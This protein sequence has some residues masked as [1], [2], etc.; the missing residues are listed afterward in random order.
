MNRIFEEG[1]W[2]AEWK[3]LDRIDYSAGVLHATEAY[4]YVTKILLQDSPEMIV[5]L[6]C[7]E[8]AIWAYEKLSQRPEVSQKYLDQLTFN[9]NPGDRSLWP[10]MGNALRHS[11][12]WGIHV[13]FPGETWL[14]RACMDLM[15]VQILPDGLMYDGRRVQKLDVEFIYDPE[16]MNRFISE[17]SHLKIGVM[18]GYAQQ[19]VAPLQENFGIVVDRWNVIE[20]SKMYSE[21]KLKDFP[22]TVEAMINMDCELLLCAAGWLTSIYQKTALDCGIRSI[23]IGTMDTFLATGKRLYGG[24]I[25]PAEHR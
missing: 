9:Y 18:G 4:E 6:G 15:G 14:S 21:P 17:I 16:M 25:D 22:R 19:M 13:S 10:L 24:F 12:A 5:P 8:C 3:D 7:T 20:C 23:D 1:H 2:P 11:T